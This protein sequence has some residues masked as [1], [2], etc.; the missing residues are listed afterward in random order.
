M[1]LEMGAKVNEKDKHGRTP[2]VA[3]VTSYEEIKQI[4]RRKGGT[5]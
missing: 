5:W 4:L 2:L 3:S 1:L